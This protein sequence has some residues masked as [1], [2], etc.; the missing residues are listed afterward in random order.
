VKGR[1][2]NPAKLEAGSTRG[3]ET[4]A[5][6]VDGRDSRVRTDRVRK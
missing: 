1:R 5:T 4:A 2:S 6:V 3:E